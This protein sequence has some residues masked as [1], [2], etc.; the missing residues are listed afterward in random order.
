MSTI[1]A[2]IVTFFFVPLYSRVLSPHD[3][4]IAAVF[5]AY[6][7]ILQVVLTYGMET[8]VLGLQVKKINPL[9]KKMKD[10]TL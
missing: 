6:I 9:K 10:L 8:T 1:V 7:A 4:G 3:Y 2:G 5:M